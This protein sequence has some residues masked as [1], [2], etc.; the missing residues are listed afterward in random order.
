MVLI[1][2]AV[3]FV[4]GI[5]STLIVLRR[6]GVSITPPRVLT[7]ADSAADLAGIPRPSR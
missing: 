2:S 7:E 4:A 3:A 1:A 6:L 5:A